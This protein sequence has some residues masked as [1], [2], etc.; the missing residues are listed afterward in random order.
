[1]RD[2]RRQRRLPMIHMTYR[3]YVHVR[4]RPLKYLL[5]HS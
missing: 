5:R 4:L 3:T 2:R 1:M